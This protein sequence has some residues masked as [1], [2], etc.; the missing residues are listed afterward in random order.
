MARMRDVTQATT[1]PCDNFYGEKDR[2]RRVAP[3]EERAMFRQI[4]VPL[5]GSDLAERALP[6]AE[7]LARATD[8]TI[9]VIRVSEPPPPALVWAGATGGMM[10]GGYLPGPVAA[11]DD[12]F[13]AE[14]RAASAYLDAVRERMSASGVSVR[15]THVTGDIA[16]ALLDYERD[17][18]ID[19]VV[20]CSHGRSGLA[21]FALGSIA[22]RLLHYGAVPVLLV[23][24]FGA[25]VDLAHAVVPLDGSALAERALPVLGHLAHAVVRAF[26]LVRVVGAGE[27]GP[28][29]ERYL[30]GVAHDLQRQD[31]FQGGDGVCQR[32]VEQGDPARAILDVAGADKLV[33]MATHGRAGLTRWAMGSVADRVARGGAGA[34]LLVRGTETGESSHA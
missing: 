25:P 3:Q 29:A 22:E 31:V 34:V 8:A 14:N 26:T 4:L 10:S 17:A 20:V 30:E 6:V 5:D 24:A 12:L 15:A 19:L 16:S 27:D 9:H 23:R 28:E 7:R 21:R 18:A 13:A 11:G 1:V 2:T 32:R 33:V